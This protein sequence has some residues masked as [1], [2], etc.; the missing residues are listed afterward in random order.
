MS[1]PDRRPQLLPRE[2]LRIDFDVAV[3][4]V[5][6]DLHGLTGQIG[7]VNTVFG[8]FLVSV[9]TISSGERLAVCKVSAMRAEEKL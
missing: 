7:F 9:S 6:A 1:M 3:A 8:S 4:P 2:V 5:N